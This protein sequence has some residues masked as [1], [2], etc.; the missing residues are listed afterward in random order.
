MPRRKIAVLTARADSREQKD[1]ICGI[2]EVAFASDADVVVFSNIQNH[3]FTHDIMNFENIVYNFFE[4]NEF[5]GVIITGEAFHSSVIDSAIE[6]IKKSHIPAVVIGSE[7]DGLVSI[8]SDDDVDM[9]NL[10]EHLIVDHGITDI[11]ILTGHKDNEYAV[12]RLNGCLRAFE[13]HGIPIKES[14]IFYGNFWYD[15]GDDLAKKYL[16]GELPMP[17]AVVCANDCMAN[18]LCEALIPKGIKIPDNITVTGYDSTGTRIYY[19][20]ILTTY[21]NNRRGIGV[22]AANYI[23]ETEYYREFGDRFMPGNTCK[24]GIDP[25]MLYN[26]MEH[27]RWEHPNVILINFAQFSM[28]QFSQELTLCRNLW[29]YLKVLNKYFFIHEANEMLLCL[30]SEWN[31]TEY[32]GEEYICCPLNGTDESYE[33]FTVAKDKLLN[34][35]MSFRSRPTVYYLYPLVFQTRLFGIASLA[36]DQPDCFK[37]LMRNWNE[38]VSNGLEFLRLKNDIHY[39]ALCQKTSSLHD[40][41]TGFCKLPEFRRRSTEKAVGESKLIAL[42]INYISDKEYAYDSIRH[43]D[44]ISSTASIIK[45]LCQNHEICGKTDENVFLILSNERTEAVIEKLRIML[46]RDIFIKYYENPPIITLEAADYVSS[47][48]INATLKAV[49]ARN[50]EMVKSFSEMKEMPQFT[51]LSKLKK[52]IAIKPQSAPDRDEA[53][54]RLCLSEG[55]FRAVYRKC[56]GISYSQD[57]INE[58]IILAK[59]LLCTTVMSVYSVAIQCGYANE[60]YFARQFH[61]CSGLS[62]AQ[63]RKKYCDSSG[64]V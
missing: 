5:D 24:C 47:K 39:L 17:E 9:E 4:P 56:F 42:K 21:Q 54:K 26:E 59:Y 41:L 40:S 51:A 52:E 62:P 28:P 23:L 6:K 53:S 19:T 7:I 32:V 13:K 35:A 16:S 36:Y 18:A 10:C 60:K 55:Y 31:S 50:A 44:I 12:R 49:E 48:T 33:S 1:I 8:Y 38:V 27:E 29:D 61:Q 46:H 58:K 63:Y 14:K 64:I 43:S 34:S 3:S 11:D 22:K 25:I 37:H 57:C 15:A 45:Q 20:P 2:A 30:D